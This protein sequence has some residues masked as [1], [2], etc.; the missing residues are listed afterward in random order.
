MITRYEKKPKTENNSGEERRSSLPRLALKT[1]DNQLIEVHEPHHV[2]DWHTFVWS[3][4][5]SNTR[6]RLLLT[7]VLIIALLTALVFMLVLQYGPFADY[8]AEL[9]NSNGTQTNI[10]SD[11]ISVLQLV[12]PDAVK[13]GLYLCM[14][15]CAFHAWRQASKT[16]TRAHRYNSVGEH[17][18]RALLAT[19]VVSYYMEQTHFHKKQFFNVHLRKIPRERNQKKPRKFY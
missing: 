6:A 2:S 15:V 17:A 5:K 3:I 10:L 16:L 14:I 12:L 18:D 8:S 7:L 13:I 9:A 4:W 11:Q 19:C 1:R